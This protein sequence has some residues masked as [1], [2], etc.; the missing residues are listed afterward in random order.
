LGGW[1]SINY[2]WFSVVCGRFH[3]PD[4]GKGNK[5]LA[6]FEKKFGV[7]DVTHT[8]LDVP[9]VVEVVCVR[10]C[11]RVSVWG[12]V[13]GLEHTPTPCISLVQL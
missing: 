4:D 7:G 10:V 8:C 6:K 5:P 1:F 2:R 3:V 11:M 13:A 9:L 12:C